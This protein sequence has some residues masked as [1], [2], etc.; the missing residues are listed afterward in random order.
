[1]E[2]SRGTLG[3]TYLEEGNAIA[4]AAATEELL[5]SWCDGNEDLL[6]NIIRR[7]RRL[8]KTQIPERKRRVPK[9][10]PETHKTQ[11][12]QNA[13]RAKRK[14]DT[15]TVSAKSAKRKFAPKCKTH[16]TQNAQNAKRTERERKTHNTHQNAKLR[17]G[18]P[19]GAG[20]G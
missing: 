18:V 3:V 6:E 12:T 13:K 10:N 14:P 5:R 20:N 17:Y 1:M 11:R 9:R 8:G 2:V 7:L 19:G 16:K 4:L 15:E